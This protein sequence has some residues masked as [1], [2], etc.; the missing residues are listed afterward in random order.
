MAENK[1][2]VSDE[3]IEETKKQIKQKK[4][5]E[6]VSTDNGKR[7]ISIDGQLKV[8]TDADKKKEALLSLTES[9]KVG[10][11]LTGHISGVEKVGRGDDA[12]SV[13]V[14]YMDDYKIIIPAQECIDIPN[15]GDRDEKK[16]TQ[17]VL[18]KRL[19][20]EIDF[21]VQG[22]N[23]EQEIVAAS[24]K[25]AMEKKKK[26][27]LLDKDKSGNFI[28]YEKAV[29]EARI[30]CTTR[31][32]IIVE[33]FGVECYVPARELSYQRIQDATQE[34]SVGDRVLVKIVQLNR[35]LNTGEV[36]ME[37]SVK[38]ALPNPYEKAMKRYNVN[39][40]Y[41]G[42]VSMIDE[43]GIFVSLEGGIDVLCK[44]PERG[45]RPPRG[46]KVTVRITT[47]NEEMNR[48]FGL[49]THI[50]KTGI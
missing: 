50:A 16:Y 31:A 44:Y 11:I 21:I 3:L 27:F 10:K 17:Y 9:Q 29:V 1:K 48:L 43:N 20:S 12:I 33:V 26:E 25:A 6:K 39:D 8:S 18:S 45:A 22:I 40:K 30:V 38:A 13:A 35:D 34:F 23:E 14:L 5:A 36:S 28:V 47:K 7:I 24:R 19:G 2:T 37:V 46:T 41:V 32:G 42:K 4:S 49:I 15:P